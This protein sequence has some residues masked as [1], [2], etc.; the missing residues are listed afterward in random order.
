[1][2]YA[3]LISEPTM[4]TTFDKVTGQGFLEKQTDTK[5]IRNIRNKAA[6]RAIYDPIPDS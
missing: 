4:V 5:L 3:E 6:W 2:Q 1:M